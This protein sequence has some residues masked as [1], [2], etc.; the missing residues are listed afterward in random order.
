[1]K[2]TISEEMNIQDEWYKETD[3][4]TMDKLPAFLDHIMN[5]YNHDYGTICHAITAGGLATMHALNRSDA[6]GI[7][8]FQA[9]YIMWQFI[10]K[11]NYSSNKSGLR[12]VDY[13]DFLYP[14]Y[15]YKF[16]KTLS[17][18]TWEAIKREAAAKIKESDAEHEKFLKDLSQYQVDVAAYISKFPDYPTNPEK[19]EHLSCGTWAE[20]E[21]EAIKEKSG[22]EFAPRKP[23]DGAYGNS[24]YQ[25][26]QSIV[27]GV[28]PF[29]Y[30]VSKEDD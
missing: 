18:D 2:Q 5:D 3:T 1:M 12:I 8:G 30:R 16:N 25:H 10:R 22:F 28:V 26:W 4:M 24:V 27:N 9:G 11:W 29:G 13:D 6:G 17:P 14:Q 19:Y 15:D 21:Q 20:W 7:T 23:Y